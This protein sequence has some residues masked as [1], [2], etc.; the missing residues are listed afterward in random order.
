MTGHLTTIASRIHLYPSKEPNCPPAKLLAGSNGP[1]NLW[2]NF[3][4]AIGRLAENLNLPISTILAVMMVEAGGRA[5]D[6]ENGLC[7]IRV[8]TRPPFT[9]LK[10]FPKG[11][12]EFVARFG[13]GQQ[14]EWK[15]LYSWAL[16]NPKVALNYTSM[17]LGQ[18]MGFHHALLGYSK[19]GL[20]LAAM[21]ESAAKQIEIFGS[22]LKNASRAMLPALKKR[23]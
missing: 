5:F 4:G 12:T 22:F 19:P 18:I 20:M 2:N 15:A 23:D 9:K 17:G 8:E 21:Q 1:A 10:R 6:N 3:G 7:I 13:K 16:E 14:A 11:G